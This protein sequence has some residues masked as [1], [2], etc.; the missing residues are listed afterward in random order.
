MPLNTDGLEINIQAP[1]NIVEAVMANPFNI[2]IPAAAYSVNEEKFGSDLRSKILNL[3]F[4][5]QDE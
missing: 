1:T 3:K 4:G 2:G 5:Q